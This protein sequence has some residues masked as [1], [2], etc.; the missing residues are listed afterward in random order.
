MEAIMVG[1][2]KHL[3]RNRVIRYLIKK[4]GLYD[5]KSG[6]KRVEKVL[7]HYVGQPVNL[8]ITCKIYYP[9]VKKIINAGA[10]NFDVSEKQMKNFFSDPVKRKG[11]GNV[12]LSIADYGITKPQKL[13]APFLVVWD[14]TKACNLK[15]KHC[16]SSAG[17]KSREELNTQ[18]VKN[19][20]DE[21]DRM[22]VTAIAFSGGEPLMRK[23]FF[24]IASYTSN[25]NIYVALATNG[26][27]IDM[28][29][30]KKLKKSGIKYVEI[31]I[32]GAGPKTHDT[33]RGVKGAWKSAVEG[34]KNSK[35]VGL[36]TAIATTAT[37]DNCKDI[38]QIIDLA[39]ELDVERLIEF[40]FIPTGR[41]RFSYEQDLPPKKREEL[42]NYLYK[43]STKTDMEIFSTA[44]Q[45]ARIAIQNILKKGEGKISFSFYGG[46]VKGKTFEIAEFI[47]G[48]G[49]GRLY[50]AISSSG[51]VKPCVFM[52]IVVGDLKKESFE[53]IWAKS[54]LLNTLRS[55]DNIKG[56]CS[57]CDFKYVCGGCR[58]RAYSYY[59]DIN[60]ADPGC[61]YNL[62]DF[63]TLKE[64][65]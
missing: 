62:K 42:L 45:Y 61:I 48:C 44:P 33:F 5:K 21:M 4:L 12:V 56:N 37:K 35:K 27:L 46:H 2:T 30:A 6:E 40:N 47:S 22:G 55:R 25:K 50:C 23:D 65:L 3:A 7:K 28:Q 20:I 16:Y 15:C 34:I 13:S 54:P 57:N 51:K 58:A 19:I 31:S 10:K 8:D 32:D 39:E 38:E 41:G 64:T 11:L 59:G 53:D 52:P 17:K 14:I 36:M 9:L 1:I 29:T 43:R 49:A 18:E 26:T 63:E 24:E 60:E